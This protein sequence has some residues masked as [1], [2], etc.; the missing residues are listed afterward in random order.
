MTKLYETLVPEAQEK[1]VRDNG[2]ELVTVVV[3]AVPH[4]D[5]P[6][7]RSAMQ[8]SL[9]VCDNFRDGIPAIDAGRT[10]LGEITGSA[11]EDISPATRKNLVAALGRRCREMD[12]R[13]EGMADGKP[14]AALMDPDLTKFF[15]PEFYKLNEKITIWS[16]AWTAAMSDDG[17]MLLDCDEPDYAVGI[18]EESRARIRQRVMRVNAVIT[19]IVE[20]LMREG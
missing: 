14:V 1:L 12:E 13:R 4:P 3:G 7:D 16:F 10:L 8:I 18:D 2:I 15:T 5:R 11:A 17:L 19:G 6:D 20:P 9:E